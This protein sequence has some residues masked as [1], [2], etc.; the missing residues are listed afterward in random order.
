MRERP[1]DGPSGF[2][3]PASV[4]QS[5]AQRHLPKT[6]RWWAYAKEKIGVGALAVPLL[7]VSASGSSPGRGHQPPPR[8][9]GHASARLDVAPTPGAGNRTAWRASEAAYKKPRSPHAVDWRPGGAKQR[10]VARPDN[11]PCSGPATPS[12]G[13]GP[14]P[15]RTDSPYIEV[16]SP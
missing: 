7:S 6:S 9:A 8:P 2:D 14:A 4:L 13:A 3:L 15:S 10:T 11:R 1:H 16:E 12:P 5:L